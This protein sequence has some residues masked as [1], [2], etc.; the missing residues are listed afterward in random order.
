M[1]LQN[2]TSLKSKNTEPLTAVQLYQ[3]AL[4]LLAGRDYS[5]AGIRRK[6]AAR[7][8]T[9]QDLGDVILRLEHEGWLD[10]RRYAERFAAAALASGKYFG[11]RLRMEMRRK[12]FS[13]EIIS[14][15]LAPLL[16]EHD[17]LAEIRSLT[18][19]RYPGFSYSEAEDRDKRRVTGFLQRRGFGFSAIMRALR[20]DD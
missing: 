17:D 11:V 8:A 15:V 18:E 10:D 4:R 6:L 19:R 7:T 1:I 3:Y 16:E 20:S 13:A 12:G 14:E 5:V 9:E 2:R